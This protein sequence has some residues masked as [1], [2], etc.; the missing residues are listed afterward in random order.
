MNML[1][2]F[3]FYNYRRIQVV[4]LSFESAYSVLSADQKKD[5]KSHTVRKCIINLTK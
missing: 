5:L 2:T 1:Y 4:A 3:R